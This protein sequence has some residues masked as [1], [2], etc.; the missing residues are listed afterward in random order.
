MISPDLTTAVEHVAAQR[1][2][3]G[4]AWMVEVIPR[5]VGHPELLHDPPRPPVPD[6][7]ER[8]DL[9]FR[10]GHH[11]PCALGRQSPAPMLRG[12]PPADLDARREVRLERGD[13]KPDPADELA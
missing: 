3:R 5:I 12:Q 9:A 4:E 6:G 2:A 8:H 10:G 1:M 13:R 7:R 11:G